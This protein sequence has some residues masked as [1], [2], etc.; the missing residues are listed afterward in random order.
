MITFSSHLKRIKYL[1]L[2]IILL[3]FIGCS[4][5][6]I[7]SEDTNPRLGASEENTFKEDNT[8]IS[9]E[10]NSTTSGEDNTTADNVKQFLW[11]H[12]TLKV[13]D[14]KHFIQHEDGTG[15]VW[16]ADTAWHLA[17]KLGPDDIDT[18]LKDRK[19]KGFNVILFSAAELTGI[20]NAA[21][22]ANAFNNLD[23][24]Q[25]NDK[26]WENIDHI[27]QKAEDIG[28]YVGILPAWD[29]TDPKQ[30]LLKVDDAK[31]YGNFIAN[32]Y[33]ERKN[34][35][36]VI[37]GDTDNKDIETTDMNISKKL[38]WEALGQAIEKV[39]GDT[40]LLTFHVRG[41]ASSSGRFEKDEASW[42]D[43]NMIQSG[44]CAEMQV[45]VKVI[46]KDYSELNISR[47]KPT[48]DAESRYE[49]I[50][51]CFYKPLDM[52]PKDEEYRFKSNDVREMAYR[53]IFAGAFGHTYG[54]Q[55]I[56]HM[57]PQAAPEPSENKSYLY[58]TT[59]NWEDALEAEGARQMGY[60]VKLMQSRDMLSRIPDNSIIT[61]NVDDND[62]NA[63]AT[64]GDGYVFVY[65]PK[66][67]TVTVK[68]GEIYGD[69]L[70]A[71]WFDPR[72]GTATVI[73]NA[74]NKSVNTMEFDTGG[75][76]DMILILDDVNK[77]YT[78]F[79]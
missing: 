54:H 67:A 4:K 71:S 27:V 78:L 69:T 57:A 21:I 56:W 2:T 45:G 62:A 46:E 58:S 13:S 35:I 49:D 26:Y 65:L 75:T 19:K 48:V 72:I 28:L 17:R 51:E 33:K 8:T 47:L 53:Q 50:I 61:S 39:V 16:M 76:D 77:N 68:L 63:V 73:D 15:F 9:N 60:I 43:F 31:H 20:R 59:K 55:S 42:I 18:Y 6:D 3:T 29:Q 41:V 52:R 24:K 38:A 74:I 30:G 64:R 37:G 12:G 23:W 7:P 14:N 1:T 44:H 10:E 32:R 5:D 70:R 66:G 11:D 79:H 25:P 40:Q 34:I 22:K 36:W